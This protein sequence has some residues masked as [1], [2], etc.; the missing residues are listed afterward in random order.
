MENTT[1]KPTA[2]RQRMADSTTAPAA[3]TRKLS[4]THKEAIAVGRVE[5]LVVQ[6]YLESLAENRPRPGRPR[7]LGHEQRLAEV[8][9]QLTTAAGIEKLRLVQER[10]D[11]QAAVSAANPQS[12]AKAEDDFVAIAAAFSLRR[13]ISRAAWR[14]L[15][16]P[17]SVLRR[18]NV[19]R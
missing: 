12:Q 16:V 2:R 3:K 8:E 6:R 10:L 7:G 18:A 1:K 19:L 13:G 17:V 14:E 5:A 9:R 11:L 4:P 15:G